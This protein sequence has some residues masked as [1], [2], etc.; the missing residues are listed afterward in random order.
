MR[1][2]GSLY[3]SELK[4]LRKNPNLK[5]VLHLEKLH[6]T[7][8]EAMGRLRRWA[9]KR[10]EALDRLPWAYELAAAEVGRIR[11]GKAEERL[12]ALRLSSSAVRVLQRSLHEGLAVEVEAV[13]EILEARL[14]AWE[15]GVAR[16]WRTGTW[17]WVEV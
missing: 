15:E 2:V 6:V 5:I 10:A 8:R 16:A 13:A 12:R 4:A 11:M 17:G 7:D 9:V 1:V 14:R 3:S